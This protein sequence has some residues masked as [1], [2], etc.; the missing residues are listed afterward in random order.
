MRFTVLNSQV[1]CCLRLDSATA[2]S[3]FYARN[4]N[5]PWGNIIAICHLF[6][7]EYNVQVDKCSRL[8]VRIAHMLA[9]DSFCIKTSFTRDGNSLINP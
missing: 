4:F 8:D 5:A 3:N 9:K 2:V 7:C 6:A 1:S